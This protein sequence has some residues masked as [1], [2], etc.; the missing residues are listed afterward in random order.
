VNR[1]GTRAAALH[2]DRTLFLC[3][4]PYGRPVAS[5]ALRRYLGAG[6][7][8]VAY[9]GEHEGGCCADEAF[10]PLLEQSF[11]CE[12]E[13]AIPQWPGMHDYLSVWR[14]KDQSRFTASAAEAA[15]GGEPAI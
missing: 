11:K 13:L 4:P 12:A 3:W 2:P 15:E 14:L 8:T 1:G 6:G 7:R 10:F 5:V 9:V